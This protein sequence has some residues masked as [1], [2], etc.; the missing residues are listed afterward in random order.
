[1]PIE[2]K[3]IVFK[4]LRLILL[5]GVT[6]SFTFEYR[7]LE[8]RDIKG[9]KQAYKSISIAFDQKNHYAVAQFGP[10]ILNKY[11][12][13]LIQSDKKVVSLRKGYKQLDS[14]IG[15][16]IYRVKIDSIK[17]IILSEKV[18]NG[19]RERIIRKL[20]NL[21]NGLLKIDVLQN[22]DNKWYKKTKK[23]VIENL[24][25]NIGD[26]IEAKSTQGKSSE[27]YRLLTSLNFKSEIIT[28]SIKNME[29]R[30]EDMFYTAMASNRIDKISKFKTDFPNF[31]TKEVNSRLSSLEADEVGHL[32]QKGTLEQLLAF[33]DLRTESPFLGEV[34]KKL[35][36]KLYSRVMST[37]NAELARIY[38]TKFNGDTQRALHVQAVIRTQ[39]AAGYGATQP[40]KPP[41]IPE[42]KF[43]FNLDKKG[44]IPDHAMKKMLELGIIDPNEK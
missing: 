14:I 1:M 16:S 12:S 38:L 21:Y 44:I 8:K 39:T 7:H 25:K 13:I 33:T 29:A 11:S 42:P 17:T 34:L 40:V 28:K 3:K 27:G 6:S 35:D 30:A 9:F 15:Y 36:K 5:L 37:R 20:D 31:R 23:I 32:I 19:N 2:M 26:L 43:S 18:N 10:G 24:E 22:Y 41:E 4:L